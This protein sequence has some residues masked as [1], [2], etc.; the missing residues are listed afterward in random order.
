MDNK[1]LV[2][3]ITVCFNA[4]KDIVKTMESVLNQDF[5]NFEYIIKDAASKDRTL[6]YIEE[7]KGK[8][9]EKGI[10]VRVYS[11][12]DEG[13]YDG[14]NIALKHALGRWI[15]FMNAGDCF[16]AKTTLSEI[17]GENKYP[18]AAIIYG[19]AVEYEYGHYYKFRKNINAIEERMPF[20]HQSAFVNRELIN[21]YPFNT[22]LKIGADYD[23]MLS[24]YKK[25]FHFQDTGKIVCIVSKDGVSSVNV[26]DTYAEAVKIKKSHGAKVP[27][28]KN[29]KWQLLDKRVRQFVTDHFPVFIKKKI[30]QVQWVIR[31][32]NAELTIPEWELNSHKNAVTK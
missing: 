7:Y 10:P 4:E 15:N 11:E 31:K 27:S 24:M 16:Y 5:T 23:F 2:T 13:I 25:G 19:D 8:F 29:M 32:Q 17:F 30:R 14:M 22:S 26:Y 12:K 18:N 3:V 9:E 21:R 28:E 1:Y 20:S 6:E